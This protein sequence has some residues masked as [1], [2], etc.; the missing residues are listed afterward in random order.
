MSKNEREDF[1]SGL[2]QL[3][4]LYEQH[5]DLSIPAYPVFNVFVFS[6]EEFVAQARILKSGK[7]ASTES[8]LVLRRK[9]GSITLDLNVLHEIG[10]ERIVVG[11][12]TIPAKPATLLPATEERTEEIVEWRCPDIRRVPKGGSNADSK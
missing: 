7:K 2:R 1:I 6:K 11:S 10:C 12:R 5:P 4:A 3:A 9:F 8:F